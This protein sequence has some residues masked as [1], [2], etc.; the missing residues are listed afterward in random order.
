MPALEA[1]Y[2]QHKAEGLRIL[3]VSMDTAADDDKVRAIMRG[4]SFPAAFLRETNFKRYGRI[5]RMPMT[6]VID[7]HGRLR[8]DGSVGDDASIDLPTLEKIVTPLLKP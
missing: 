7:R 8:H 1:Y 5:W 4:Y 3:A 6:F 2:Q